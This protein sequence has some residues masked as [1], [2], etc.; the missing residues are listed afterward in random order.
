[1]AKDLEVDPQVMLNMFTGQIQAV[2]INYYP[3]CKWANMVIGLSPHSDANALTVLL[4]ANDI[5]GLQIKKNGKWYLVKPKPG[6]FII[7]IG[8]MIEVVIQITHSIELPF[9]IFC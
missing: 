5:N 4:Q 3:P 2:R 9:L 1:M 6:A 8:D 7:N